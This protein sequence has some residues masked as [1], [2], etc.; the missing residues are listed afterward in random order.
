MPAT[1]APTPYYLLSTPYYL[2]PT[3]YYSLN[4]KHEIMLYV[5][6]YGIIIIILRVKLQ[7]KWK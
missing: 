3:T 2:L 1:T 6:C 7:A 5:I 4:Q